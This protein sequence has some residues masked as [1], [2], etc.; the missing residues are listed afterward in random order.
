M[1]IGE[2]INAERIR[3]G[4]SVRDLSDETEIYLDKVY[5]II[6]GSCTHGA[7]VDRLFKYLR[8]DKNTK[9]K[10]PSISEDI[11]QLATFRNARKWPMKKMAKELG[12]SPECLSMWEKGS[13]IPSASNWLKIRRFLNSHENGGAAY[14][15][16]D[17]ECKAAEKLG[18]SYGMY[19]AYR[20]TG[21]LE[22]Y[23]EQAKRLHNARNINVIESNIV[24]GSA[25]K[26]AT[27]VQAQKL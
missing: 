21:T 20:D 11:A 27:R 26:K 1:T 16:M 6:N 2:K 9:I 7:F 17:D 22:Q 3:R 23:C 5:E 19:C 14:M 15:S 8:I 25:K 10:K 13:N 24:A 4:I 12:V 18:L